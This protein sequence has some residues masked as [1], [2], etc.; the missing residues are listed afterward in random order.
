MTTN[1]TKILTET[2]HAAE[3]IVSEEQQHRSRKVG[4]LAEDSV[5]QAGQVLGQ[6]LTAAAAVAGTSP[7]NTGNGV[8][9][10]GAIGASAVPGDY[11]LVAVAAAA[12]AGT[13]NLYAPDGSL[14]R[15]ITVGGGATVSPHMT[16]TIADGS[17][18][19]IVGD[20]FTVTVTAGVYKPVAPAATDGTQIAVALLYSAD[21]DSTDANT[22]VT[23]LYRECRYNG[24][25][26]VFTA[27]MTTPEKN[28]A[29]AQLALR[30]IEAQSVASTIS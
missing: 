5:V 15:Q 16:I 6:V 21:N 29:I 11:K 9:T 25:E 4:L 13:F 7:A 10:V 1:T 3:F 2:R 22:Q 30:G 20:N 12:N 23:V 28:A 19:F 26:I 8:V 27:G 17:A 24:N 18:D 14:I